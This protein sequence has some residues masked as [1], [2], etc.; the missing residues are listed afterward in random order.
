M[1]IEAW[2]GYFPR[3]DGF[4]TCEVS[5]GAMMDRE[6]ETIHLSHCGLRPVHGECHASYAADARGYFFGVAHVESAGTG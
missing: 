2:K 4:Q 3:I 5:Q 1:Q 6:A